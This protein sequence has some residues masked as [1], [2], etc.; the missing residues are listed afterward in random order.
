MGEG[1]RTQAAVGDQRVPRQGRRAGAAADVR[2][3]LGP[4]R[5]AHVGQHALDHGEVGLAVG[6]QRHHVAG[7]IDLAADVEGGAVAGQH[8]LVDAHD[9][10]VEPD[11]QHAAVAQLVVEQPHLQV[12]D[13][14]LDVQ[15]VGS[16]DLA[17]HPHAAAAGGGGVRRQ[18][19]HEHPRVRIERGVRQPHRHLDLAGVGEPELPRARGRQPRRGDV[20]AVEHVEPAQGHLRGHLADALVADEQVGDADLDVVAG[21]LEGAAAGGAEVGEAGQR[22]LPGEIGQVERVHG[23]AAAV[24]V[25]RIGAVPAHVGGAGDGGAG[26]LDLEPV[27]ADTGAL[28]AQAG[29][30]RGER[31]VV[32]AA[33]IERQPAEAE[34]LL[35]L[36]VEVE[37]AADRAEHRVVVQ[38]E[39]GAEVGHRPLAGADPGVDLFAAVAPR[40][41]QREA[42]FD[43]EARVPGAHHR[44]GQMRVAV[45]DHRLAFDR[46]PGDVPGA[47]RLAGEAA[48]DLRTRQRAEDHA[49]ERPGAVHRNRPR[50]ATP[51][52]S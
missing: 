29:H 8:E 30:G 12:V 18:R 5:A 6:A 13:H 36:A 20:E 28:E 23:Q 51:P 17:P 3:D 35:V 1:E 21:L 15:R 16:V 22:R 34:R 37:L 50:S 44:P 49:V 4:A 39:S 25:E 27:E 26:L 47:H 7:Q 14:R 48:L 31:L 32:G 40:V 41:A 2:R 10:A 43:V 9:L 33:A 24:G 38:F 52:W 42:A 46:A 11:P 45:L 19:R